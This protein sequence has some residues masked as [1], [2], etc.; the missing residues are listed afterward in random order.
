MTPEQIKKDFE[1]RGQTFTDWA[2]EHG[3]RRNDVYRVLNGAAKGKRGIAHKI[4]VKLGLKPDLSS[5]A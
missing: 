3:F 5:A 1:L 4:A 2:K